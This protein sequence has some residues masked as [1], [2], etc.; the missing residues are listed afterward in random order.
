MKKM[1][2]GEYLDFVPLTE[3]HIL[4][5]DSYFNAFSGYE[6]LQTFF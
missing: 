1:G 4:R 3:K 5:K 2:E 6:M